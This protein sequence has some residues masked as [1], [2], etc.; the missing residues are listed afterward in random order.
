[1]D[2]MFKLMASS[3]G[4]K[5]D[6]KMNESK[7]FRRIFKEIINAW[8]AFSAADISGDNYLRFFLSD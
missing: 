1:M 6:A 4:N 7:I 8:C 3:S 5:D 2:F